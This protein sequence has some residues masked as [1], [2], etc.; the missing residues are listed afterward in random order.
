MAQVA[1]PLLPPRFYRYRSI[2]NEKLEQELTAIENNY[3]WCSNFRA[4]NDPMEGF[5]RTSPWVSRQT[6]FQRLSEAIS[7]G[8]NSVGIC[9]ISDTFENEL[10]WAHYAENYNGICVAYSTND[11]RLALS[12]GVHIV[13]IAYSSEPPRI[14]RTISQNSQWAVRAILSH[15]KSPWHY[16]NEWRLLVD[17]KVLTQPLPGPL[18]LSSKRVAKAVYLGSRVNDAIKGRLIQRLSGIGVEIHT[19]KV[20]KYKHSWKRIK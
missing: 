11:L 10:M 1:Q 4:L 16:E 6:N 7:L 9:C 17:E 14:N 15:K 5:Y 3:L 18:L 20:S 12:D 19:M 8:K 13:R 2:S